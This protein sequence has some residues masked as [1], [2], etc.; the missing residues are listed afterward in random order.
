M[1]LVGAFVRNRHIA[2]FS[3]E[4][5]LRPEIHTYAGGLGVL[6]G[7]TA[8][9]CAA[10]ELPLV[11]VT[12]VSRDGYLAQEIDPHGRQIDR[13]DPWDPKSWAS[14]LMA[15]V[16]VPIEGREV[17][18]RPWL[19]LVEGPSR[20]AVPVIMLDTDLEE[21]APED[22]QI[23]HR[24]YGGDQ[25]YRLRQEIVL[26]IGGA[27]VL[28]ALG[29]EIHTYH[30]NEG[31]AALL[32]LELLRR[33]RRP[34]ETLSE[35]S[36]EWVRELCKACLYD[37]ARIREMCVFT[38]HTPIEAG[39]DRFPYALIERVL[40]DFM[41]LDQLC[42]L[43]GRDA[44][45]MTRVALN[46]SGYVNGVAERHAE[47]SRRLFPGYRIH[48]ITNGVDAATWTC[49]SFARLYNAHVPHWQHE[50]ELL[51]RAD[52][53]P[54]DEVWSAH[55][56]AKRSLLDLIEQ[57]TGLT[58]N[59][60]VPLIVAARRMTGYKRPG[61]LLA[62]AKRLLAIH[63]RYPFQ[64]VLAGKA[65]PSDETGKRAI[66]QI[67]RHI[68]ELSGIVP[69]A[70]LRNYEMELA[71]HMVAGADVW[72]N[73]PLPPLEASGTSGMKAALNGVLNLS[74]PDGWWQ[75]ALIEDE[76]GWAIGDG[77][78][79]GAD[80]DATALYEKLEQKV[81]PM[82]YGNHANWIRMMRE[83]ISKI[84]YYF[85]SHRMMRRYAAE[86]YLR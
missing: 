50:P 20:Y 76:I 8:R 59:L 42:L 12:L 62:D 13:L 46:L 36:S 61:L 54:D 34:A 45:N 57:R 72:L 86:A 5:A 52:R 58:M 31:H 26:G 4:I 47:T 9:A 15:K 82:Y 85:N 19:Y 10:L 25:A 67:H 29:F 18:V 65:H 41:E 83:S 73:T 70:F 43:G 68:E 22:R 14:S 63:R 30:L 80:S 21:N 64:V 35:E 32:C 81:L 79:T 55:Q 16:A 7:D 28:T 71:R 49:P 69:I 53:L 23:T 3:M 60:E 66:E 75:E 44:F 1:S 37:V 39:H 2:Y 78:P 74:V 6:A 33:H 51:V 40:P 84:A 27:R 77:Q 24:L 11:F 38:T 17:W 48:S 56:E